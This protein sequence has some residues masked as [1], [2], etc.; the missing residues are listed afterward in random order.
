MPKIYSFVLMFVIFISGCAHFEDMGI[1][2]QMPARESKAQELHQEITQKNSSHFQVHEGFYLSGEE[3]PFV[4]KNRLPKYFQDELTLVGPLYLNGIADQITKMF[5]VPISLAPDIEKEDA[6]ERSMSL[7]YEGPLKLFLDSVASYYDLY[8]QFEDGEIH[9]F[10][11]MTKTY[12]L[13]ASMSKTKVTSTL[14]NKSGG[15][16]N[17]SGGES[18]G[19]GSSKSEQV[20]SSEMELAA[21]EEAVNTIKEMLSEDGH[22]AANRAGGTVTVTDSP[23]ILRRVSLY[24]D[25]LNDRQSRQIA[26]NVQVFSFT[27]R[28]QRDRGV[29]GELV[30]TDITGGQIKIVGGDASN[31]PE[32]AGSF[33]AAI[34]DSA[35]NKSDRLSAFYGSSLLINALRNRGKV[36]LIKSGSG[37]GMNNQPMSINR[38]KSQKYLAEISSTLSESGDTTTS[39]LST[40]EVVTGFSLQLVPHVLPDNR[41]ILE[42]SLV[43]SELK[44]IKEITSGTNKIQLPDVSSQNFTQHVMV[45]SGS[46]VVLAGYANDEL[47]DERQ[48]GALSIGTSEKDAREVFVVAIDI[49]DV[50][51]R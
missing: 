8:W 40:D 28:D 20:I 16:E 48:D 6:Y 26:I 17:S 15:S 2:E 24:I 13:V 32:G 11:T 42:Y 10:K 35:S 46:T 44:E 45:N 31:A 36:S 19:G 43:L 41:I 47:S 18:T 21:W 27:D 33:T 49:N 38:L 14:S 4:K 25:E 30:F 23:G 1:E 5:G 12:S 29:G 22:V 37:I 50:T 9:F 34:I 51:L 7:D 39:S 3:V